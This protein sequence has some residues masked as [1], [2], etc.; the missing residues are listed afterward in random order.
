MDG[1][2]ADDEVYAVRCVEKGIWE[3]YDDMLRRRE[4]AQP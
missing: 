1:R 2:D 4:D 3:E